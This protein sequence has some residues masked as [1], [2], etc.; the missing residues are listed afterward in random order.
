MS[1]DKPHIVQRPFGEF[2][3]PKWYC[4]TP[5]GGGLVRVGSGY[6]PLDAWDKWANTYCQEEWAKVK[7][8]G[9]GGACPAWLQKQVKQRLRTLPRSTPRHPA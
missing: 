6:T 1:A 4:E 7:F 2:G 3:V 8:P 5:L 9:E